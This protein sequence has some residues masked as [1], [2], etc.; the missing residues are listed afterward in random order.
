MSVFVGADAIG[1]AP[2]S[3]RVTFGI[4]PKSDP[5]M[6]RIAWSVLVTPDTI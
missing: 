3:P 4:E 5:L 1:S 2:K 6:N